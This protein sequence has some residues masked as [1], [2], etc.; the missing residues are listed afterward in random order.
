MR[1]GLVVGSTWLATYLVSA[2]VAQH[3]QP[4]YLHVHEVAP[5]YHR[6]YPFEDTNSQLSHR[7]IVGKYLAARSVKVQKVDETRHYVQD[8]LFTLL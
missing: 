5:V 8:T 1:T 3:S 2:Q 6:S 4:F 7:F